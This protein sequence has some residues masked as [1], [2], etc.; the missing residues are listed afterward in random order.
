MTKATCRRFGAYGLEQL[1]VCCHYG[2]TVAASTRHG[3]RNSWEL[4]SWSMSRRQREHTGYG[5]SV[6]ETSISTPSGTPPSTKP[7]PPILPKPFQQLRSK[8]S[9]LWAYRSHSHSNPHSSYKI[10][11]RSPF[12]MLQF[13]V[14]SCFDYCSVLLIHLSPLF[15][16]FSK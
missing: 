6:F 3:S 14:I 12:C 2:G 5:V 13:T 7:H 4:T 9:N 15:L 8:Y 11:A 1:R 10:S 16:S